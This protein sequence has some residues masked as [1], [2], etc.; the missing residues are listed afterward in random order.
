[1]NTFAHT[2]QS[3]TIEL[4]RFLENAH[5]PLSCVSAA[6]GRSPKSKAPISSL[7]PTLRSCVVFPSNQEL[8][9]VRKSIKSVD[10]FFLRSSNLSSRQWAERDTQRQVEGF[11]LP[12]LIRDRR[13]R[14]RRRRLHS[15]AAGATP[16]HC[17]ELANEPLRRNS[18]WL[19]SSTP[20]HR[21]IASVG[22]SWLH[23]KLAAVFVSEWGEISR[24]WTKSSESRP[25]S[26]SV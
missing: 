10:Y 26:W 16:H 12:Q 18:N 23:L 19:V 24:L 2:A 6:I 15:S 14:R 17:G 8:F 11:P 21:W 3:Q 13:R 22:T 5:P 9:H 20:M 1:M 25:G 7:N 4:S